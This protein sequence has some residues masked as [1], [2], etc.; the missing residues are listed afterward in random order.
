MQN[1]QKALETQVLEI[2]LI[3]DEV[4]GLLEIH[5]NNRELAE[6]ALD[7]FVEDGTELNLEAGYSQEES[8]EKAENFFYLEHFEINSLEELENLS[9]EKGEGLYSLNILVEA[10]EKLGAF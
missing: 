2:S 6:E 10:K 3:S 5:F 7:N 1:L 4:N 9:Q 8:K